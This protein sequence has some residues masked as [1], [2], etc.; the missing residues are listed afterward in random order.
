MFVRIFQHPGKELLV[1]VDHVSKIEVE[2]AVPTSE[3]DYRLVPLNQ[4]V[5]DPNA[6]RSY[7][8]HVAGEVLLLI[9][10]PDDPVLKIF[11]EIYKSAVQID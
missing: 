1:N 9:A 8:V 2:Y 5:T 7:R 4:G 6:V 11:E 10:N 3:G